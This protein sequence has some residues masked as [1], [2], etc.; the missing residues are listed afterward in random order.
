MKDRKDEYKN[1]NISVCE[2]D[3]DFSEYDYDNKKAICSCF[4]KIN[5]PMISQIKVDK[6]KLFSNFKDIKNIG[7]FK[8][9][10]CYYLLFDKNNI[11]KNSANYMIIILLTLNIFALLGFLFHDNSNIRNIMKKLSNKK[12][13]IIIIE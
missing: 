12:E 11:F 10:K 13:K 4:I 2:E 9:F 1:S 5:I 7:N 6:E 8:M 3:C